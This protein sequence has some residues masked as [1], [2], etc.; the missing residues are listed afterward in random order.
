MECKKCGNDLFK[1]LEYDCEDCEYNGAYDDEGECIYNET[2]ILE[3]KLDRTE[4]FE[5]GQ[6]FL[7]VCFGN[8]CHIFKCSKCN[9][10]TNMPLLEE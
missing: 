7:G 1:V 9:K 8:G 5:D 2:E 3:K 6:C 10:I 4:A